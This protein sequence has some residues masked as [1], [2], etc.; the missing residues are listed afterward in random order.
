[1]F[2]ST[3]LTR[4]ANLLL[5]L[6][7]AIVLTACSSR[8]SNPQLDP[9]PR[10]NPPLTLPPEI[11]A[12][13][14]ELL[15]RQISRP[16]QVGPDYR[17]IAEN[18]T[19]RLYLNQNSSAIIIED[20]R[21]DTL[22][23][24]S[25]T[26]LIDEPNTTA[27]WRKLIEMPVQVS[28]VDAERSQEKSAKPE[29]VALGFSPLQNGV[30]VT[31][32]FTA[33]DLAFDVIY[34]LRGD[35]LEATI[36]SASIIEDGENSLVSIDL[37][38]FLGATHDDERG[39][40][41]YPDGSGALMYFD[42]PHPPEV[43]KILAPIYGADDYG[44]G[45]GAGSVYQESIVMPVFGLVRG[46]AA[47]VGMITQ[48]D[49]DAD[50]GVARSG[51][52]VNYNHV[53]AEFVFRRQGRF[54]LTGGQP[55][56]LYQPDRIGGDRQVRF[57]FLDGEE[58][59]YVGMAS[60][61]RKYLI[62]ERN[63]TRI[64]GAPPLANFIFFMGAERRTWFLADMIVM[65]RFDEVRQMTQELADLGLE[66]FDVSLWFWNEGGTQGKYP[67]HLPVDERLGAE[68]DLRALADDLQQRGQ[69]LYLQENY[70]IVAPGST[71]VLPFLDVVRGV[72]GLPAGG[73]EQ[74]YLLNPQVALRDFAL[75]DMPLIAS[76]G[77]N[78]LL[79][80]DFAS[81]ALPD[82]NTRYPLGRENFA[83]TW[84]QIANASREQ[85]GFTAMT[86]SNIYAVPYADRLDFVT[87]DSTHYD[88]FDETIPL[89]HIAVHG[90]VSYSGLPYN[91]LSDG[92]RSFLR[93]VEYGALPSFILTQESSAQ[94]F[95]TTINSIYSSRYGYWKD[96]ILRQ[97]QRMRT[98][99]PLASH[100]I[101][102]HE[103][104]QKG[105]YRTTYEN[106][107]QVIV[108]YTSERYSDGT[109]SVPP[110][111]FIV[112]GGE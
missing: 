18:P 64:S 29:Q 68:Q 81:L 52:G 36:V 106:G 57:C 112:V 61:Y 17:A 91:L 110:S 28:Y 58:A 65:T 6:A 32:D 49:F 45:R 1:M 48:G 105:I 72:D 108:N 25:P 8:A 51:K 100:F 74:G 80:G 69:K 40:I 14:S 56:W 77:A 54:S 53:W 21:N 97:Y 10:I 83:A 47:F 95:R 79:L 42:T 31:Y 60:R 63:A 24:S 12:F 46:T 59:N 90:L 101:I 13:P 2:G 73:P 85:L 23:R 96:E 88:L 66:H 102:G 55:S 37:L 15:F 41:V 111:D 89:F 34:A 30:R 38:S 27:A 86:G 3:N 35:C 43:Q 39:Y 50:L 67:K 82:K 16:A 9:L 26:D 94:L 19:L 93:Q 22:W 33:T 70:Y 4:F 71:E 76:L 62:E 103:R 7:L 104:L 20:L 78:G 44:G 107:A 75:R 5:W 98:L 11:A 99:A 109:I 92:Q 87:L 84:M